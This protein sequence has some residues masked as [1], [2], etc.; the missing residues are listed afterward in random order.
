MKNILLKSFSL[1]L[2]G[3]GL[4]GCIKDADIEIPEQFPKLVVGCFIKPGDEMIKVSVRSSTPIFGTVEFGTSDYVTA[5]VVTMRHGNEEVILPYSDE[6]DAYVISTV[7]FP[8]EFNQTYHLKVACE[9]FETV[10]AETSTP[11]ASPV[12]VENT[13]LSIDSVNQDYWPTVE[14]RIRSAWN[15]F[16]GEGDY[17]SWVIGD[18]DNT[19]YISYTNRYISDQ[20]QDQE[21]L[22]VV[23]TV[24]VNQFDNQVPPI[25]FVKL[26]RSSK[27]Y[28][29]YH[30]SLEGVYDGGDPFSEPQPIYSN[31]TNGLGCFAGYASVEAS[32]VI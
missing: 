4:M 5:A 2:I 32:I 12:F 17:Y 25:F 10:Y 15:D 13:V 8:I 11:N 24:V 9:G 21:R 7:D 28:Y 20:G 18:D 6:E 16:N 27:D 30:K 14:Y 19:S 29:L 23:Q 31:I 26:V 1:L 3:F 22:E